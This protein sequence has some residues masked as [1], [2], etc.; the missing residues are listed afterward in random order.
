[1]GDVSERPRIDIKEF[2]AKGYLQELNRIFLHPFGMAL[3]VNVDDDG[4]ET[5]GGIWDYRDD[6][7]GIYYDLANSDDERR[8][9]FRRNADR[10]QG[11]MVRRV[12]KRME[13]LGF[14]VEP[15]E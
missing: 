1:M 5:L 4:K 12:A 11:E 14:A 13:S 8:E 10:V 3:E 7:E 6:E 2:R 9:R 15:V